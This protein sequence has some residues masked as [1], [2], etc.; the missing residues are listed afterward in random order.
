MLDVME[1]V[2][3]EFSKRYGQVCIHGQVQQMD[4]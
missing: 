3:K 4:G 2:N 1:K